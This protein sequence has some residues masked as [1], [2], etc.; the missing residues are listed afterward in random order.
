MVSYLFHC[1]KC[2]TISGWDCHSDDVGF[3]DFNLFE[4]LLHKL[5]CF[6]GLWLC[7]A[8]FFE[9]STLVA[10]QSF[11]RIKPLRDLSYFH[12]SMFLVFF[13]FIVCKCTLRTRHSVQL[14]VKGLN[15]CFFPLLLY[16]FH[17]DKT[18]GEKH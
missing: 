8:L 10:L 15:T 17:R 18:Y 11:T 16:T 13:L 9:L 4:M 14:N 1:L 3:A 5:I 7:S 12:L 2:V 6:P